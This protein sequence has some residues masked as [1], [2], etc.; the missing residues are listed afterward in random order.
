MEII[1]RKLCGNETI[2]RCFSVK[3]NGKKIRVIIDYK[4]VHFNK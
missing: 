3:L 1:T 4:K 2:E